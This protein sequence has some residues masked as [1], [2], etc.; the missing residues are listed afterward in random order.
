MNFLQKLGLRLKAFTNPSLFED[1]LDNPFYRTYRINGGFRFTAFNEDK[2]IDEGYA[3][4]ADLYSIVRKISQTASNVPL[5]LYEIQRGEKVE[6]EEGELYDLINQPNRLQ[7]MPEML[8]E[9]LTYLLLTG[10]SF[11]SGYR[12]GEFGLGNAI[13][14]LNILPS[15]H[16]DIQG[17]DMNEPIEA[18]WYQEVNNI[19]FDAQDVMHVRYPNPKGEGSERLFGMSPLE[20]GNSVLQSSNNTYDA[21]GSIIKN[22]GVNGI[23]S[24]ASERS[25]TKEQGEQM[26]E[27][28]NNKNNNPKK[29]GR[30]LI[31]SAQ[32]NYQALGLSPDKLQLIESGIFDLRSLCRIYNVAPQLFGDDASSTYNNINQL[33]K[34][35]YIDAVLPNLNLWLKKFNNWFVSSWSEVDNKEYCVEADTSSIEVLQQDQKLEAEKDKIKMDGINTVLAMPINQEAKSKLLVMEYGYSEEDANSITQINEQE[36]EVNQ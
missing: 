7:T 23:I 4:N 19:R 34:D 29:F 33:R 21:R 28:W 30:N 27:A 32:V 35:M 10:N 36:N 14:E 22:Q 24:S 26:Q 8:E 6:V 1:V 18:Y 25:F 9:S 11:V 3:K 13:R 12:L 20:A 15:Q 16:V 17:G 31:T 5:K 2:V